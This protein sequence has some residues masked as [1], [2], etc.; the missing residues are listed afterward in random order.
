M[1]PGSLLV[2]PRL[3]PLALGHGARDPSPMLGFVGG[4]RPSLG[5]LTMLADGM[6]ATARQLTLSAALG[7]NPATTR[8]PDEQRYQHDYGNDNYDDQ[9][10]R[11]SLYLLR[12]GCPETSPPRSAETEPRPRA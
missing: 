12:R 1:G 2:E 5:G 11:H 8:Q 3:G 10:G 6:L 9:N 4:A 7:G